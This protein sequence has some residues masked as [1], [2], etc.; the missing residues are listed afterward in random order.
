VEDLLAT[1]PATRRPPEQR[2]TRIVSARSG[3]GSRL[4]ALWRNR[5]LIVHLSRTDIKVKYKNSALGLLWS[6]VNPLM[7][8]G[9]FYFVF[10]VVLANGIRD[11]V[12]F[13]FAG[14]MVWNFFQGSVVTSTGIIVE[15]AG[16]VKKV[17]FPREILPLSAIGA[18]LV[19]FSMQLIP[20]AIFMVVLGVPPEWRELPLLLLGMGALLVVA[21][22]LGILLSAVNVKLRDMRHLIEVAMMAWFWLT[23]IVYSFQHTLASHLS[24]YHLTWLYL[25]NP[26]TPI[27]LTFQ[28]VFYPKEVVYN[29]M[30]AKKWEAILP[31]WSAGH[32]A[33]LDLGVLAFG[34]VLFVVAVAVFGRLEGNF[35]EEL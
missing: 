1:P 18:Q 28:R 16:I 31:S 23:P 15:R 17:S 13:L 9:V 12:V 33:L 35:A 6:L 21:S 10:Q 34:V 8:L 11:Y 7:Q 30:I 19:Y 29:P 25:A 26:M 22:G 32:I 5:D 2:E 14:L 4:G 24:R 3:V 27:V 20:M